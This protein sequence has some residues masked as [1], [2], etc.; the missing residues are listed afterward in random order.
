MKL[1][2]LQD[3]LKKHWRINH[4]LISGY[5]SDESK[6]DSN[7]E[8]KE[9]TLFNSD[10]KCYNCGK[11]SHKANKC[12]NKSKKRMSY[13][14]KTTRERFNDTCN[15][16]GKRGHKAQDC[17]EKE[18]NKGKRPKR[19]KRSDS[20]EEVGGMAVEYCLICTKDNAEVSF[21]D[22]IVDDENHTNNNEYIKP[23]MTMNMVDKNYVKCNMDTYK[24][25]Q[26]HRECNKQTRILLH[27]Y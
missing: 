7:D 23:H 3:A 2:D 16:C 20:N 10:I 14:N 5:G 8:G 25:T 12:P 17:W 1:D 6:E 4:N 15:N 27:E 9:T 13:R 11:S 24:P 26:D 19:W 21:T 22:I 18:S